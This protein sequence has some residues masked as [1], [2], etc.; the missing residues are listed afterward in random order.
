MKVYKKIQSAFGGAGLYLDKHM[1]RALDARCGDELVI[2]LE[3]GRLIISKSIISDKKIEE[4]LNANRN[5]KK[6]V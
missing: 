3:D 2:T 1:L 5:P 6:G 4:L